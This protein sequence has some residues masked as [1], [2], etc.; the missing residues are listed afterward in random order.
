ML[1][2]RFRSDIMK[3]FF[4]EKVVKYGQ[5]VVESLPLEVFKIYSTEGHI[6][7]LDLAML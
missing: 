5:E 6:S 7:A 1:A 2:G 3:N 4:T